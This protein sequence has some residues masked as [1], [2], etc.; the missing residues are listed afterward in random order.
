MFRITKIKFGF[1]VSNFYNNILKNPFKMK[2]KLLFSLFASA[3][4]LT[5]CG[6]G[7]GKPVFKEGCLDN[8]CPSDRSQEFKDKFCNSIRQKKE[9][10]GF[11]MREFID[12]WLA[13]TMV[14]K[15]SLGVKQTQNYYDDWVWMIDNNCPDIW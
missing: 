10:L 5:S 3:I 1:T 9:L 6:G 11:D 2:L 13:T 12:A 8:D 4:L 15:D 7:G 14:G